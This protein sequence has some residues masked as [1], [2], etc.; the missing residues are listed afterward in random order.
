MVLVKAI[1]ILR[2]HIMNMKFD[3]TGSFSPESEVKS[4]PSIQ[5]LSRSFQQMMLDGPGIMKVNKES[6]ALVSSAS[7]HVPAAA[8]SISQLI[9]YNSVKHRSTNPCI[10]R[11][12]H[13]RENPLVIY[14][15][16]KIYSNTEM[17]SLV[18]SMHG[19]GLQ[20]RLCISYSRLRTI[21]TDLANSIICF[22][23]KS[24]VVV[25]MQ[26]IR[27]VFMTNAYDNIDHNTQATTCKTTFH[28]SC[29]SVLQFPT[30][31]NQGTKIGPECTLNTEVMGKK[32]TDILPQSYTN[33]VDDVSLTKSEEY[34]VPDIELNSWLKPLWSTIL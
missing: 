13:T 28:G 29:C 10:P 25:P 6:P 16:I 30:P 34:H 20:S 26:A 22:Y 15:A 14:I 17:K 8:L 31:D 3:F 7:E 12:I 24:G 2:K 11:H 33:M 4:V 9:I 5:T 32:G 1:K 23:E 21:S 19:R 18:D 27:G